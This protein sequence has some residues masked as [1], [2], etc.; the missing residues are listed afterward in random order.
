MY[1]SN[2][3][4]R[5]RHDIR[6]LLISGCGV[7]RTPCSGTLIHQVNPGQFCKKYFDLEDPVSI[8]PEVL[9]T[10]SKTMPIVIWNI[11]YSFS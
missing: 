5:S 4:E 10:A 7:K 8:I 9:K 11:F 1:G 3:Q 6:E 2:S